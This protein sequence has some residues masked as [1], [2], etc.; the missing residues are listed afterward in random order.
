MEKGLLS[1]IVL[2]EVFIPLAEINERAQID[3]ADSQYYALSRR[4]ASQKVNG[5]IELSIAWRSTS[6]DRLTLQVKDLQQ[7]LDDLEELLAMMNAKEH[8]ERD[9]LF[10]STPHRS[11]SEGTLSRSIAGRLEVKILE[12]RHLSIPVEKIKSLTNSGVYVNITCERES[13]KDMTFTTSSAKNRLAPYWNES[14]KFE[15]VEQNSN[16][17]IQLFDTRRLRA[18]EFLG[19]ASLSV[20]GLRVFCS[21]TTAIMFFCRMENR[22]IVGFL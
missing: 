21:S 17:T 11:S 14:F 4:K 10:I 19:Q 18:H 3:T 1:D 5:S 8:P 22:I 16:L 12:A 13:G 20:V 6:L 7:E 2:G 15:N 9:S